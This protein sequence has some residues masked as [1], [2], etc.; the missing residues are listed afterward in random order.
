M[1]LQEARR[2]APDP[3]TQRIV[4]SQSIFLGLRARARDAQTPAAMG[5]NRFITLPFVLRFLEV[6]AHRGR[7]P[8]GRAHSCWAARGCESGQ[9]P[10]AVGPGRP[11]MR[12]P[13]L[14]A[15]SLV[16]P[17]PLPPP[18]PHTPCTR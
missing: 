12:C 14:L 6:R 15:C 5:S 4:E 13:P 10:R 1:K 8:Q 9:V 17:P 16:P 2:P 3:A 11:L 18:P 7:Q